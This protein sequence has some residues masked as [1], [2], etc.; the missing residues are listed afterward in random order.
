MLSAAN[1]AEIR[2]AADSLNK[3]LA[4]LPQAPTAG[5]TVTKEEGAMEPV[6]KEATPDEAAANATPVDAG[7]TTG[8]GE[9]RHTGPGAALP[10]DGPQRSLPGDVPGRE[11]I[12]ADGDKPAMQAVFDA[13]GNLVGIVDPAQITPVAGASKTSD[14]SVAAT[15]DGAGD[16]SADAGGGADA[17][18]HDAAARR[19][20][21]APPQTPR[22]DDDSVA[23]SDGDDETITVTK[24]GLSSLVAAEVTALLTERD[25][26]GRQ[27][28]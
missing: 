8:M 15:P 16:G 19:R 13:D 12:K 23:K 22:A 25:A 26:G 17:A 5:D 1:E 9:P 14:G 18:R 27:G 10:G 21:P 28:G 24:A 3:V 20:R 6:T 4:A 7:G 11:V 2:S